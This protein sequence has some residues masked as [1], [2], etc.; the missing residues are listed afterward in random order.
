MIL[1]QRCCVSSLVTC[2]AETS[3]WRNCTRATCCPHP[4]CACLGGD[5]TAVVF[6]DFVICFYFVSFFSSQYWI[7]L[8]QIPPSNL[9]LELPIHTAPSPSPYIITT[10]SL[11]H[12]YVIM[13][14]SLRHRCP[15][16]DLD[17]SCDRPIST[18]TAATIRCSCGRV[19]VMC[20]YG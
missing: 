20:V 12:H 13:A 18:S 2:R 17:R 15:S 11:H 8:H 14:S 1:V 5:G 7:Y 6:V 19:V 4:T 9:P 3:A 10:S 16:I